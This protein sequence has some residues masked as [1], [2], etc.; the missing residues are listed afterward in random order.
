MNFLPWNIFQ[1]WKHNK[2][3]S[4]VQEKFEV[5]LSAGNG[6]NGAI[7]P[8]STSNW[9]IFFLQQLGHHYAKRYISSGP[10]CTICLSVFGDQMLGPI[11]E[12]LVLPQPVCISH[13]T[14]KKLLTPLMSSCEF[15]MFI[16]PIKTI[17]SELLC[18]G[19]AL[20]WEWRDLKLETNFVPR[21]F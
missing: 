21:N 15:P 17:L 8:L 19:R 10:I 2:M 12:I 14:K 20:D 5:V 13:F 18:L 9:G 7:K 4:L 16:L 11:L 1:F 6:G 3:N